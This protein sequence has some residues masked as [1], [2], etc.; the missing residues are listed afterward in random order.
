M[1]RKLLVAALIGAATTTMVIT[2]MSTATPTHTVVSTLATP[3]GDT[4]PMEESTTSTTM[5]EGP[6]ATTIG[7]ALVVEAPTTNTTIPTPTTSTTVHT[8]VTTAPVGTTTT[9]RPAGTMHPVP[10]APGNNRCNIPLDSTLQGKLVW[11]SGLAAEGAGT[12]TITVFMQNQGDN[13][14]AGE[15]RTVKVTF[16]D[17]TSESH[18]LTPELPDYCPRE[19]R[20]WHLSVTNPAGETAEPTV[21]I[22]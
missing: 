6:A 5:V 17:G 4:L 19:G 11:T 21:E 12:Y 8:T 2:H 13:L 7:T 22:S 9:T 3:T 18:V 20:T 10:T 15:T 14:I 16:A 1:Y